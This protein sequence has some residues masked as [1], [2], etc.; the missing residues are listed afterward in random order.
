[1]F[2]S[3][4]RAAAA[5][6]PVVAVRDPSQLTTR[7]GAILFVDLNQAETL[8]AAVGWSRRTGRPV[9][10]FVSHVDAQLIRAARTAGIGTVL[11]RSQLEKNLPDLLRE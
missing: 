2:F 9:V 1:M 5:G 8:A 4:I 3:K 6:R 11:P 10:G 7:D